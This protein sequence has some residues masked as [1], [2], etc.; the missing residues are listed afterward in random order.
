MKCNEVYASIKELF[1]E[2]EE[3]HTKFIDK[4]NKSAGARA[5][6][7]IGGIKKLVTEYRKSSVDNSK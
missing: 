2:F 7:A 5:R 1:N 3:N 4:G 6:K